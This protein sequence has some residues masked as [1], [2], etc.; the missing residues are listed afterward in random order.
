[1]S[2][3]DIEKAICSYET[4]H[5]HLHQDSQFHLQ[6]KWPVHLLSNRDREASK[7]SKAGGITMDGMRAGAE[8]AHGRVMHSS[9]EAYEYD[10]DLCS[11]NWKPSHLQPVIQ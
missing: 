11:L 6:K 1:M 2:A 9:Q 10:P 7:L 4:P 8:V 3:C 5:S